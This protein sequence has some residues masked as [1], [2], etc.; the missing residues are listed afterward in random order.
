[1]IRENR[2]TPELRQAVLTSRS[3]GIANC[4]WL[5]KHIRDIYKTVWDVKPSSIINAALVRGPFIDQ[6]Q[7]MN[8]F[9]E[10]PTVAELNKLYFYAWSHGLKTLSYYVHRMPAVDAQ[11][12]QA[13]IKETKKDE[14]VVVVGEVC[15]MKDGC[16][17]CG[18]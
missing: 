4:E 12:I 6:S 16:V 2:W 15:T 18:S 5:P 10:T 7:S 14:I 17:S 3:G 9:I 8:L 13:A 11:K 1:M